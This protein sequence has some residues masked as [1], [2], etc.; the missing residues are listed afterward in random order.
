ML[1]GGRG[2]STKEN[3]SGVIP[4]LPQTSADEFSQAM[5]LVGGLFHQVIELAPVFLCRAAASFH[6]DWPPIQTKGFLPGGCRGTPFRRGLIVQKLRHLGSAYPSIQDFLDPDKPVMGWRE[7]VEK[8]S[9]TNEAGRL[10]RLV[11]D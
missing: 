6:T 8:V 3:A 7:E 2:T 1:A 10:D 4:A 11:Q 5:F 9:R